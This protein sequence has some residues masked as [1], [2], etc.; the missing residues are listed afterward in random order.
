MV[1]FIS[2]KQSLSRD[3]SRNKKY[4]AQGV[5]AGV[6]PPFL[7]RY[8]SV[9][10]YVY[11]YALL[12]FEGDALI[13]RPVAEAGQLVLGQ[14][15]LFASTVLTAEAVVLPLV[16]IVEHVHVNVPHEAGR[17]AVIQSALSRLSHVRNT[18]CSF[19]LPSQPRV[20]M[21]LKA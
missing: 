20:N 13:H 4:T 14:H 21:G 10:F 1:S 7:V 3:I 16:P 5:V 9:K 8:I 15:I 2:H 17:T 11:D 18:S 6:L 19:T 12:F